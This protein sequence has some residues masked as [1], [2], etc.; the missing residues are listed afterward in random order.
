MHR[1]SD[2]QQPAGGARPQGRGA[3]GRWREGRTRP[4]SNENDQRNYR[5]Y[6]NVKKGPN[7][8]VFAGRFRTERACRNSSEFIR[9][10]SVPTNGPQASPSSSLRRGTGNDC[11]DYRYLSDTLALL[12]GAVQ[13]GRPI[14]WPTILHNEANSILVRVLA[15][16]CPSPRPCRPCGWRSPTRCRTSS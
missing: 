10:P 7:I 12:T 8:A 3:R 2:P 1:P 11:R 4:L 13:Q 5:K 15:R 9:I 16:A 14:A 6:P